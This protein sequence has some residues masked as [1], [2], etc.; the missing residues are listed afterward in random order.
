MNKTFIILVFTSLFALN[1]KCQI[2]QWA[3]SCDM[4]TAGYNFGDG[5]SVSNDPTG[6]IFIVGNYTGKMMVGKLY[7]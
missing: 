5:I 7:S 4:D 3:K 1:S 2:W 6:N